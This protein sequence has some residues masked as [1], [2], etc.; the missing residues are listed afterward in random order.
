MPRRNI[1]ILIIVTLLTSACYLRADRVG[2]ILVHAM[3][4]IEWRYLQNVDRDVL[5]Q[6]AVRGMIERLNENY[7]DDFTAYIPP[8]QEE[9]FEQILSQKYG[10]VGMHVRLA[11]GDREEEDGAKIVVFYPLVSGPAMKAGVRAGDEILGIDDRSTRGM[12]LEEA[13]R[14]LRG[15]IGETVVLKVLHPE[16]TEPVEIPIERE[17]IQM[18]TVLGDQRNEDG[19]WDFFL[20]DE[21][22]IGYLRINTFS[23]NTLDEVRRA[24][25]TLVKKKMQGLILDLRNDP[26]GYL[27]MAVGICDL[28]VDSGPIVSTRRR[29]GEI[30]QVFQATEEGTYPDFP[31]AVLVNNQ[32]ASASEIVAACLQDHDRAVIIGQRTFGKGTIQELVE[33]EGNRGLLKL[34]AASYWRPSGKNIHRFKKATDKD[35]WGVRPDPG[36]EVIVNEDELAAWV[37]SRLKRDIYDPTDPEKQAEKPPLEDR[38][39]D[40]A[41]EYIEKAILNQKQ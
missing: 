23:D 27:D 8:R 1:Y 10:G 34:T 40:R 36:F 37:K 11:D 15:P 33:L 14:L 30:A 28:F 38:Q 31:I 12:K 35:D 3:D 6:G 20:D 17:L 19:S 26:G 22:R 24:V 5:F 32:S 16:E 21:K 41:V 29:G 18:D 13:I 25:S 7:G 4:E 39:L 9:D 2:R